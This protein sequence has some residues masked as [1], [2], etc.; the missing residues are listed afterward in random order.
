MQGRRRPRNS[1]IIKEFPRI[2]NLTSQPNPPFL[3]RQTFSSAQEEMQLVCYLPRPLIY[4]VCLPLLLGRQLARWM[5]DRRH[6]VVNML[7]RKIFKLQCSRYFY[8]ILSRVRKF[9]NTQKAISEIEYG[10]PLN[11][12]EKRLLFLSSA[13]SQPTIRWM[14]VV[15]FKSI[16]NAASVG[17]EFS[18]YS[19]HSFINNHSNYYKM[20]LLSLPLPLRLTQE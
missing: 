17:G 1:S 6:L 11:V 14:Q 15:R 13:G 5:D 7:E 3:H 9:K 19:S 16:V 10:M 12:D 20:L 4:I 18:A 8:A 2:V